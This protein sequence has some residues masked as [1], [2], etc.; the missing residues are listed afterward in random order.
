MSEILS[1]DPTAPQPERLARAAALLR[2]GGLVA[3]STDTVYGLAAD[4]FNADAVE[5]I[6]AAKGRA[7]D[8]PVLL[9]V[10]SIEMAVSLSKNLPISFHPLVKRYWPGPLTIVVEASERIPAAVTAN[11]G[12]VG[13]RLPAAAIPRALVSALGGPITGTSAN[14][15]G[16]PACRSAAEAESALGD[17]VL[18]ILDGGPSPNAVPSTVVRLTRGPWEMIREGAIQRA[19]LE[20][21]FQSLETGK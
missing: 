16:R 5:K 12:Q 13:L 10:D 9:L 21:F 15:S 14:R 11:T 3:I 6:F 20:S 19:E 1:V 17:V 7:P 4:P 18:L 2:S 8:A